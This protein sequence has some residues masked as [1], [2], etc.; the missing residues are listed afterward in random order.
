[1]IYKVKFCVNSITINFRI[2]DQVVLRYNKPCHRC[3]VT[4]VDPETGKLLSDGEPMRTLKT[5]RMIEPTLDGPIFA[6]QFGIDV[7]GTV[8]VGD[9]V[10][11]EE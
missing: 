9:E 2:G 11:A 10:Y 8:N 1:M 5:Y 4:Q 7:C 3:I 6:I